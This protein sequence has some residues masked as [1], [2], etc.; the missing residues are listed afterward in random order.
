MKGEKNED[1]QIKLMTELVKYNEIDSIAFYFYGLHS[2]IYDEVQASVEQQ[3]ECKEEISV[4]DYN[5]LLENES[6]GI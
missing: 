3:E 6:F 2:K 1:L 4:Q 5:R